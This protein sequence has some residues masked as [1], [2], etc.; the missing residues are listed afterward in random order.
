MK[1]GDIQQT[2]TV[3]EAVQKAVSVVDPD[4]DQGTEDFLLRFEDRDEPIAGLQE[5]IEQQVDEAVGAIDPDGT[6]PAIQMCGAVVTYLAFRRDE[7]TDV[8]EDV[9]RLAAR[10]EFADGVPEHV[11]AWLEDEGVAI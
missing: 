3:F 1:H 7:I 8:R 10:A 11:R 6:D 2:P 4:A 5:T 9:L